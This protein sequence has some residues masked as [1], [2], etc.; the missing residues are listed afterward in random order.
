MAAPD[1]RGRKDELDEDLPI[2]RDYG[3]VVKLVG[4]LLAG[5]IVAAFVGSKI[6]STAAGCGASLIRPGSTVVPPVR[7][8]SPSR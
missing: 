7:P 8:Q 6:K 5:I 4:A 3:F 1:E 2:K